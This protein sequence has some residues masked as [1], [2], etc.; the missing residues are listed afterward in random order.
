VNFKKT[1]DKQEKVEYIIFILNESELT[2]MEH[3]MKTIRNLITVLTLLV[4]YSAC[5]QVTQEWVARYNGTIGGV[6]TSPV[7][8]AVGVDGSVYITGYDGSSMLHWV[9]VKYNASGIQQWAVI[10][11][12]SS[13]EGQPKDLV[14]DA[15]G[16]VYVTGYITTLTAYDWATV[17]YNING[18]QQWEVHYNGPGNGYDKPY[19]IALDSN[20][21]VYVTGYSNSHQGYPSNNDFTTIK[22]DSNGV[23]Q[24]VSRYNGSADGHDYGYDLAVDDSGNVVV[25]GSSMESF[26]GNDYTTIKYNPDGTQQ[27]IAHYNYY[28]NYNDGSYA[29]AIDQYHNVYVTGA[30]AGDYATIKY[31]SIGVQQW[32]SRYN[33]P[34]N[35]PDE[36]SRL[37]LD[38]NENIY[39]TGKSDNL[40]GSQINYDIATV[41]YNNAG[42]QQWVARYDGPLNLNDWP[43]ALKVDSLGNAYVTGVTGNEGTTQVEREDYV[44][45]KYNTSGIQQWIMFYNGPGNNIDE[46]MDL[47]LDNQ[48]HVYVTG[49]SYEHGIRQDFCTIKYD[50]FAPN[51]AITLTPLNP[52]IIIPAAGGA[53]S[54]NAMA[55]NTTAVPQ[56]CRAWC[57]IKY[58]NGTWTGYVLGP[59]NLNIPANLMVSRIRNQNVPG[60]WAAGSYQ[61]WGWV[62]PQGQTTAFDSSFFDWTKA[63]MDLNSPLKSWAS[64]GEDFDEFAVG[65]RLASPLYEGWQEA[66]KHTITFDGSKL[67]SGVYLARLQ[68]GECTQMQKMVLLK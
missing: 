60:A 14:I 34:G 28:E 17:K 19:A 16:S 33:G 37:V 27:W 38:S 22:Y 5:A 66:G 51:V 46:A 18:V 64:G 35:G 49:T 68:A 56:P 24:W 26:Q 61:H 11:G 12:L 63:G 40:S 2:N 23:Q 52:P 53:Y 57:K 43:N 50:Q 3:A 59:L 42:V 45:I 54:Y 48:G 62:G 32:V 58:P 7:A 10:Y 55:A 30:S 41:K 4:G 9:T 47:A 67:A 6:L 31:N 39:V 8:V 29:L 1:L 20:H 44:T 65:A 25:T 13:L 21:N 15:A 36:A